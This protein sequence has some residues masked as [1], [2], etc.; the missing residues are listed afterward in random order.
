MT[1]QALR[2]RFNAWVQSQEGLCAA[3]EARLF[4]NN[5][6]FA[7][8]LALV[9]EAEQA[10]KA[11]AVL[12]FARWMESCGASSC[13]ESDAHVFIQSQGWRLLEEK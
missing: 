9:R 5:F 2:E 10:A 7:A 3:E 8:A 12:A 1:D 11:E 4:G 6:V 13:G